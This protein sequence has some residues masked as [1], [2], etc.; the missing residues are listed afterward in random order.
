[1]W[2]TTAGKGVIVPGCHPLFSILVNGREKYV[3]KEPYVSIEVD[4]QSMM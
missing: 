2:L 3:M 1:V 4:I